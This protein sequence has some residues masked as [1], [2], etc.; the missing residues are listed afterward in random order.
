MARDSTSPSQ[1]SALQAAYTPKPN[2][3]LRVTAEKPLCSSLTHS[4]KVQPI[5]SNDT[6][7]KMPVKQPDDTGP[8][9]P[10]DP[11][12]FVPT[13]PGH[14]V[15]QNYLLAMSCPALAQPAFQ[16]PDS[17]ISE[18]MLK[19]EQRVIGYWETLRHCPG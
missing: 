5:L 1:P 4:S 6:G 17:E 3:L 11:R 12:E 2:V 14:Q 18:Q 10:R 8:Q 7:L 15:P 9:D 19:A 16:M 13:H